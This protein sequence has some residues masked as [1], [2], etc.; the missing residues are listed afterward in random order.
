[1]RRIAGVFTLFVALAFASPA[2]AGPSGT[3]K[4]RIDIPGPGELGPELQ[5]STSKA[6]ADR[7]VNRLND[8][9]DAAELK[10]SMVDR[11]GPSTVEVG[12]EA[13]VGR[14]LLRGLALAPGRMQLRVIRHIGVRWQRQSS[15]L[16]EGVEI[17]Q[18]E[19]LEK[20]R[21]YLWSSDRETLR[22][23]V[24]Q[25][26]FD[27][28]DVEMYATASG[29][30][31]YAL[32]ETVATHDSVVGTDIGH[33]ETGAPYVSVDLDGPAQRSFQKASRQ[34][35]GPFAMV[36][37]REIVGLV[38]DSA[39]TDGVLHVGAPESVRGDRA[40]LNWARQVAG[41]LAA[42][43]PVKIVEATE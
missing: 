24:N 29:W 15:K 22:S 38:D 4:M 30:R 1:M 8:R 42:P 23:Y 16:P 2:L 13:D 25:I 34:L 19:E 40:L 5:E 35:G 39:M 32:G 36:L 21:A 33:V 14:G 43:I 11:V 10:F 28:V 7:V 12:L 41:R 31:T 6:I 27:D 20:E 17:R 18:G 37:D 26:S 3:I 9:V